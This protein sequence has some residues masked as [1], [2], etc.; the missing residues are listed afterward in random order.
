MK[1]LILIGGGGHC[2]SCIDAIELENKFKIFG[3]LD[4]QDNLGR[5][6]LGYK[7]I[8]TDA[9]IA[10][11]AKD[12]ACYFLITL[13]QIK[14]PLKRIEIFNKLIEAKANIATII[15]PLAYI[16]KHALIGTGTIVL[17]GA[18]IN[19]NARIGQNCIINTGSIIEHDAIVESHCHISTGTILN[20]NT[21][22]ASGSFIG[23]NCTT[24]EGT[25]IEKSSV[26]PALSFIKRNSIN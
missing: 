1:K 21:Y 25:K 15:S 13:G 10:T 7:V 19:S 6:I 3:I 12:T 18:I 16:S 8:G 24:Q 4:T 2:H 14:T 11:L 22:I 20:G 5:E 9:D 23:S 17:H 26:V